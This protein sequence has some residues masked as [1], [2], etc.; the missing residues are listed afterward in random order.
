MSATT[1]PEA[2]HSRRSFSFRGQK[3]ACVGTLVLVFLCGALTGG[4][5]MTTSVA[6]R[7]LHRSVPFWT[8][9]GRQI[10]LE[11]WKNDLH[12]TP[13]QSEEISSILE[14]FAKYYRTV[15]SEAKVRVLRILDD[16]QRKQFEKML[17]DTRN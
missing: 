13:A 8:D 10:S 6:Q 11:R 3:W 1:Q 16:D 2:Y 4:A 5:L 14:D 15:T 7:R 12:L 9:A 17:R